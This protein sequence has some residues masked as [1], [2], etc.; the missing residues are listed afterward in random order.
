MSFILAE[1]SVFC[2]LLPFSEK[3]RIIWA[4]YPWAR[5]TK[6]GVKG[7]QSMLTSHII[8]TSHTRI[9]T[10]QARN[11]NFYT[12]TLTGTRT[13][14]I[15]LHFVTSLVKC[16]TGG[17]HRLCL[18]QTRETESWMEWDQSWFTE[19]QLQLEAQCYP[20]PSKKHPHMHTHTHSTPSVADRWAHT[21]KKKT[22]EIYGQFQQ[23]QRFTK[24]VWCFLI[25]WLTLLRFSVLKPLPK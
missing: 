23:Q 12:P 9:H 8:S 21:Y 25:S 18:M 11:F 3:T 20:G 1:S 4:V 16:T 13:S 17:S 5:L 22:T 6:K 2:V 24:T 10:Q 14:N 19:I 7:N 15:K